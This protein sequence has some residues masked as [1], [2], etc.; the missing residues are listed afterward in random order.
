[1]PRL[2]PR[3]LLG[4]PL[5]LLGYPTAI[6]IIDLAVGKLNLGSVLNAISDSSNPEAYPFE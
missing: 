5:S 2:S 4:A 6:A 1:M 3:T